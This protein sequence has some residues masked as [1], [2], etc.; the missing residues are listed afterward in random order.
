MT[1]KVV[2]G[3]ELRFSHLDLLQWIWSTPSCPACLGIV[4]TRSSILWRCVRA[5]RDLGAGA[6]LELLFVARIA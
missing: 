4:D 3:V 1:K 6:A 5:R 2:K